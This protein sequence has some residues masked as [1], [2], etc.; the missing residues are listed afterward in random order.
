LTKISILVLKTH[1][2]IFFIREQSVKIA[3]FNLLSWV[4]SLVLRAAEARYA[5]YGLKRAHH[6]L[7]MERRPPSQLVAR[8]RFTAPVTGPSAQANEIAKRQP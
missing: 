5:I 3:C 4:R 6:A 7:M 1:C 2:N 8:N